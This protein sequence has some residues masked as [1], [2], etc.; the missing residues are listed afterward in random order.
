VKQI[1]LPAFCVQGIVVEHPSPKADILRELFPNIRPELLAKKSYDQMTI[2]LTSLDGQV[3]NL[4]LMAYPVGDPPEGKSFI[5]QS[6]SEWLFQLQKFLTTENYHKV[7]TTVEVAGVVH[8]LE[9]K[10]PMLMWK[11]MSTT[12]QA[13]YCE[14]ILKK[15]MEQILNW[16]K[17]QLC[18]EVA[19]EM[20][21]RIPAALNKLTDSHMDWDSAVQFLT[22]PWGLEAMTRDSQE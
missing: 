11:G 13:V 8:E 18:Y 22:E 6:S 21:A 5:Y 4:P 12:V 19:K 7:V 15:C 9:V 16:R 1:N 2:K 17:R 10:V 20:A 3:V 14:D